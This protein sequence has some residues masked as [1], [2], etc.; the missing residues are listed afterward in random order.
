MRAP[1][2]LAFSFATL[3]GCDA[4]GEFASGVR[5]GWN[6]GMCEESSPTKEKCSSC[7]A[8][9]SGARGQFDAGKCECVMSGTKPAT[10]H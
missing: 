2:L 10:V 4:C 8:K 3:T 9:A 1:L 5:E 6:E 7:C